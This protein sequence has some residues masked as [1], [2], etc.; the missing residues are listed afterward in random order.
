M[1]KPLTLLLLLSAC[2]NDPSDTNCTA[3]EKAQLEAEMTPH[4]VATQDGVRLYRV[5]RSNQV[6]YFTTPCGDTSWETR[7][8]Q[9]KLTV[10]DQNH[11]TGTGCR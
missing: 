8:M 9:G 4:L 11:V 6:V 1:L 3:T 10:I 7:H 2:C 5:A